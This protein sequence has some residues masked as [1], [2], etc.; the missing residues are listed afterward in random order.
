[1]AFA[2]TDAEVRASALEGLVANWTCMSRDDP[3]SARRVLQAL[4]RAGGRLSRLQLADDLT[5]TA[6]AVS[7]LLNATDQDELTTIT[8]QVGRWWP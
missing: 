8:A 5:V 6:P 3:R 1:M 7:P 4:L 2:L